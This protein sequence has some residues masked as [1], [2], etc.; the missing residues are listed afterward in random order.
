MLFLRAL[1]AF[2]VLPAVV[3]GLL[4]WLV[5]LNDHWRTQGVSFGWLVLAF[6]LAVALWCVRDF[7][8]IGKGT[9]AP[10][11]PPK[12]LVVIGLYRYVRNPMYLGVFASVLGWSTIVGSPLMAAYAIAIATAFHLRVILYEEPT[13][14]RLFGHEW[15]RYRRSVNR[16][17]PRL[18]SSKKRL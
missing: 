1:I 17:W 18:P 7:Y 10:W 12:T 14:E 6:G 16:W 5:L 3:G 15:I 11:D 9:L 4:P 8:V 2:L 13:L